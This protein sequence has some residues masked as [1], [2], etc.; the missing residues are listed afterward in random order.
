MQV[1]MMAH[2]TH[3]QMDV[4]QRKHDD[5]KRWKTK[6]WGAKRRGGQEM[7]GEEMGKGETR[8]RQSA[9]GRMCV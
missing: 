4:Q 6:R 1:W 8:L 7:G 3:G 9:I 2:G 5:T